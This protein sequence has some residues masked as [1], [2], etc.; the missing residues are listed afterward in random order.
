MNKCENMTKIILFQKFVV[1]AEVVVVVV[2]VEVVVV[3]VVAVVEEWPTK[4]KEIKH[5]SLIFHF[6]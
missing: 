3:E 1:V 4:A 2:V 6:K 5:K